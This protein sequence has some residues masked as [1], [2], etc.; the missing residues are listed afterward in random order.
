MKNTEN[1]TPT[2]YVVNMAAICNCMRAVSK[3]EARYY[4]GGVLIKDIDGR[5]HYVGTDGHVMIHFSEEIKGNLL[6]EEIILKPLSKIKVSKHEDV[7][8]YIYG[9][10][11]IIDTDTAILKDLNTKIAC[12]VIDGTYPDFWRVIPNE[13]TEE[14]KEYIAFNPDFLKVVKTVLGKTPCKPQT[15]GEGS[16]C[17]WVGDRYF[18]EIQCVV[19]PIRS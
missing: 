17:M 15:E 6:K 3:E 8:C 4:L 5:R 14:A 18:S 12:D 19:M 1:K 10:L 16:V 2:I 11:Q 7:D 9:T 13:N